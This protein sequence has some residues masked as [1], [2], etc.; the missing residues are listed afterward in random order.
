MWFK[1]S[2]LILRYEKLYTADL[3]EIRAHCYRRQLFIDVVSNSPF[4]ICR[5]KKNNMGTDSYIKNFSQIKKK[6]LVQ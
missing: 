5:K 1:I 3:I 4:A 2:Y 6:L